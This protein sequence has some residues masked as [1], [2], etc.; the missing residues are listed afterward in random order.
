MRMKRKKHA[1]RTRWSFAALAV[2]LLAGLLWF[3]A[4]LKNMEAQRQEK[5]MEQ[6]ED[7]IRRAAVACY[8]SEGF[9]PPDLAYMSEHYGLQI[10][11][12]KYFVHYE[13]IAENLMPEITVISRES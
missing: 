5:G 2:L 13:G 12:E 10:D 1:A 8:A 4:A 11:E 9:Y 7:A 6:L 3:S